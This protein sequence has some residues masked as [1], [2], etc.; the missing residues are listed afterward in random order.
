MRA[1]GAGDA[2]VFAQDELIGPNLD[3]A[4]DGAVDGHRI[5]C[6]CCR[7]GGA[8][9]GNSIAHRVKT[10]GGATGVEHDV[11]TGYRH[12]AIDCGFG[13]IDGARRQANGAAYGAVANR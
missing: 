2:G 6:K 11:L 7:L 3:I 5:A 1:H 4:L 9:Q 8:S 12:A 13:D 10:V